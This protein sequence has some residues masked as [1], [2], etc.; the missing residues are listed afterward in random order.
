MASLYKIHS[1]G[2]REYKEAG[3]RIEA[4]AW[5]ENGTFKEVV[6]RQIPVVNCSLLIGSI[7]ARTY[8][9]NDYWLT[10]V[11]TEILEESKNSEGDI[12]S[13][14]FK[15]QNSEYIIEY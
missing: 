10:T 5:N 3:K 13:I 15:T 7:T 14:R 1:D 6:N 12:T 4:I 2:S 8:S 11:V 9:E